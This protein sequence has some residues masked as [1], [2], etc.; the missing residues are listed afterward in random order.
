MSFIFVQN[1]PRK[2]ANFGITFK[3]KHFLI[4]PILEDDL[5]NFTDSQYKLLYKTAIFFGSLKFNEVA[6]LKLRINKIKQ[7]FKI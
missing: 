4:K 6:I 7:L 1:C 3:Y 2:V 5:C